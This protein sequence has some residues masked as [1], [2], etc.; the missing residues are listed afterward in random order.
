MTSPRSASGPGRHD[1]VARLLPVSL[2]VLLGAL[3]PETR[4]ESMAG[5]ALLIAL[6]VALG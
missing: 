5:V 1:L 3:P 4:G 6:L 2:L